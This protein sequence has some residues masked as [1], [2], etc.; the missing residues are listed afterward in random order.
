MS[1]TFITCRRCGSEG[2]RTVMYEC[3]NGHVFRTPAQL[4]FKSYK[5]AKRQ[6]KRRKLD[7]DSAIKHQDSNWYVVYT[8]MACGSGLLTS[9]EWQCLT[10]GKV[11]P[12]DQKNWSVKET[13]DGT[14]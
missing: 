10:C 5:D 11:A 6:M 2:V 3:S 12:A 1:D 8:C 4:R 9:L 7:F 14:E 13:E